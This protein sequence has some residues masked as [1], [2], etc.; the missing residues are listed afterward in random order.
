MKLLKKI[1]SDVPIHSTH[2]N[3]KLSQIRRKSN[4]I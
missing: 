1:K 3:S 4:L 2:S